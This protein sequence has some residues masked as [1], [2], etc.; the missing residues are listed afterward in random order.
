MPCQNLD[1][2]PHAPRPMLLPRLLFDLHLRRRWRL[3]LGALL[4]VVSWLAFMPASAAPTVQHLDKVQHLAAFMTLA[5]VASLCWA[6]SRRTELATMLGLLAYGLFIEL[7]QSQLPTRSASVAD[8][9]A[10]AAGVALG[11]LLMRQLR[12][13]A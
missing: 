9:L 3:L 5:L 6:P 7:V 11:L 10:D 2:A 1:A 12:P 4:A 8:W 13:Q